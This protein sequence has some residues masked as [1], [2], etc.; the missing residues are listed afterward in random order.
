MRGHPD[1]HRLRNYQSVVLH[2]SVHPPTIKLWNLFI[3]DFSK[4]SQPSAALLLYSR[5]RRNCLQP[6][7]H[8]FPLLLKSFSKLS[9]Q[10]PLLFFAD[11]IKHGLD[12]D[13]FVRNSLI[14]ALANSGSPRLARQ[15]MELGE[16]IG[17]QLVN[18]QPDHSGWYS[19]LANV[20]L[21]HRKWDKAASVRK[22]MKMKGIDKIPGVSWIEVNGLIRDFVTS[23]SLSDWELCEMMDTVWRHIVSSIY[24]HKVDNINIS[25]G[26]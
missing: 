10:D 19:L 14:S 5:M 9:D 18:L 25:A 13:S 7:M 6:D 4:S 21:E 20:H 24:D 23:E 15:N 11:I 3:R 12:L 1:H 22:S 17:N 2:F 16:Y 8:T 26:D